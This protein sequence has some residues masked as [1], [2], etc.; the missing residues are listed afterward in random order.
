MD[1]DFTDGDLRGT[2]GIPKKYEDDEDQPRPPNR[3]IINP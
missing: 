3:P 2:K 1:A